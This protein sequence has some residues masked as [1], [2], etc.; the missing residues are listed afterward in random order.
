MRPIPSNVAIHHSEDYSYPDAPFHPVVVYPELVGRLPYSVETQGVNPIYANV[1]E[2]LALLGCDK[3]HIGTPN[4]SPFR[5]FVK[6]GQHT[7]IKPNLVRAKHPMGTEGVLSM[8]SHASLI[9]PLIDYTLLANGGKGVI[10]ICDVPLQ[11]SVWEDLITYSGLKDLVEFYRIHGVDIEL[12]DLRKE[13][14]HNNADGV[15]IRRD[16]EE[17][18]PRGYTSVDLGKTGR[19]MGVI[20][21]HDR[22][23]ITDYGKGTVPKHHNPEVNEYYVPNTV[24]RSDFFINVPK[25]KTH[26][27]T[28]LTCAMKNLVGINGDKSWLAHHRR[29]A[30]R[31][32]GDEY[33]KFHFRVWVKWHVFAFLKRHSWGVV[34]AGLLKKLWKRIFWGGMSHEEFQIQ[35]SIN[36]GAT[37]ERVGTSEGSWYGN[38]T[39]WRCVIDLNNIIFFADKEGTLHQ[40]QQRSY[41]GVVDGVL[42]GER[43]GPMEQTPRKAGVIITGTNPVAI[44]FAAA[45]VMGFDWKKIPQIREAMTNQHYPLVSFSSEEISYLSN[46]SDI[47]ALNLHFIPTRGWKEMI[48]R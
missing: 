39:I 38:D 12:L 13:I 29:G 34:V 7:V 5:E 42:A 43:E 3:E 16:I 6:P 26:R 44:D 1:R 27:K 25:L 40:A 18:D 19:L 11:S 23:E 47:D 14:S 31:F 17:R 33:E 37:R 35:E 10:S 48:E 41:L 2:T 30:V 20:G 46:D 15:I 28:G 22:F 9:R 32:G 24:L 36:G 45:H 4:W 8:I 21:H